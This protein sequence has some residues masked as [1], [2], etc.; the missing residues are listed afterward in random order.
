M[1]L[2]AKSG[3]IDTFFAPT[4]YAVWTDATGIKTS[5]VKPPTEKT[6]LFGFTV[7]K[8][9]TGVS[10]AVLAALEKLVDDGYYEKVLKRWQL[11]EGAIT[12]GIN[13]GDQGS[14]FG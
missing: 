11:P 4:T 6:S 9:N 12:P 14:M 7:G 5:S 8:D 1:V 13:I 3:R 10:K 2:A